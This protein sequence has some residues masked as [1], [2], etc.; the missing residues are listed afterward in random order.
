[1]EPICTCH[2]IK[3]IPIDKQPRDFVSALQ[4]EYRA[5]LLAACESTAAGFADGRPHGSRTVLLGSATLSGLFML[6]VVWP[7]SPE[8]QLR[9]ICLRDGPQVLVARGFTQ[10]GPRVPTP[11]IELAEQAIRRAR[12]LEREPQTEKAQW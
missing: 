11:E 8:P 3:F 4:P 9:L 6:H 7:G 12:E 1:M 10:E 2:S 5:M